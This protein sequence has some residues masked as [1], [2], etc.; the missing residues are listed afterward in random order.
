[1][2]MSEIE[3]LYGSARRALA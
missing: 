1:M 2:Q 3:K